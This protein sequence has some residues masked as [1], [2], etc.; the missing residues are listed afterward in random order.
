MSFKI[1][2]HVE[3]LS[4]MVTATITTYIVYETILLSALAAVVGATFGYFVKLTHDTYL[5]EPY[6]KLIN[7]IKKY[8]SDKFK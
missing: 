2:D 5:K 6:L 3:E 8:I 1:E 7:K 4:G